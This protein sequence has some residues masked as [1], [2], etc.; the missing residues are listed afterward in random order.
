MHHQ[1]EKNKTDRMTSMNEILEAIDFH[2][3]H[4]IRASLTFVSFYEKSCLNN[5]KNLRKSDF[6]TNMSIR[7]F[8]K[9]NTC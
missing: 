1:L 4:K 7:I 2:F 3:V 9:S 8:L 5:L 6:D